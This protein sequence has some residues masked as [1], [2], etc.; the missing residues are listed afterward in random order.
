MVLVRRLDAFC[1]SLF[2]AAALVFL[3]VL[4]LIADTGGGHRASAE[5]LEAALREELPHW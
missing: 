5:A 1:S 3:Q 2:A 4:F